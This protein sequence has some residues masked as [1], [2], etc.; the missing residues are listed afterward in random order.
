M[1][2]VKVEDKKVS[3]A[4]ELSPDSFS[5]KNSIEDEV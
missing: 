3:N 5:D 1:P 4:H 2:L